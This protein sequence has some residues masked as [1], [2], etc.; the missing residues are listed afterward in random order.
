MGLD[1]GYREIE[2]KGDSLTVVNKVDAID[3]DRSASGAYI[4]DIKALKGGFGRCKYMHVVKGS[5]GL[6]HILVIEG[7]KRGTSSY[8]LGGVSKF[9][10]MVVERDKRSSET[11]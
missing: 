8:S 7:I 3:K 6:A 5:N 9:A 4:E 1:L 2:I 10:E 11:R